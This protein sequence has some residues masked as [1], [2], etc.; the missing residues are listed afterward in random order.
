MLQI[1]QNWGKIAN[2]PPQC[3]TKICTTDRRRMIILKLACSELF[4]VILLY[5]I[6]CTWLMIFQSSCKHCIAASFA[7]K[8]K[9]SLQLSVQLTLRF[10]VL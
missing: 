5:L 8:Q 10:Q 7:F 4:S 3:S 9:R 2:Y 6:P 1:G